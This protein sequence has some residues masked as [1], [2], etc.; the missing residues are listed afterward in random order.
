VE[1]LGLTVPTS[2]AGGQHAAAPSSNIFEGMK[3]QQTRRVGGGARVVLHVDMD[4]FFVS[5]LVRGR[6][7]LMSRALAVAHGSGGDSSSAEISSCN[8]VAR[9]NGVKAGMWCHDAKQ[10]CPSLQVLA[11]DFVQYED[12]SKAVLKILHR[13]S[14]LYQPVSCDEAYL[15]FPVGTDGAA[16]AARLRAEILV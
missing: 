1:E 10:R 5:V 13:S 16:V 14:P 11:Y 12:V 7:G 4:C 8:Y 3:G 15:E 2:D 9:A 6:P